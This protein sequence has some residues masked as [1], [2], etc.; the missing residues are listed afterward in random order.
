M[1]QPL[2]MESTLR[3]Q[4]IRKRAVAKG[5]LTRMQAYIDSGNFDVNQIQVRLNRLPTI[6]SKLE[7]VQDELEASDDCDHTEDRASFETQYFEIEAKF[8]ELLHPVNIHSSPD[9]S[10]EHGSSSSTRSTHTGSFQI[11]LPTIEIPC[12]DGNV[13]KWLHY[14]DT[15][16]ALIVNNKSLSNVQKFHYLTRVVPEVP[17]LTKKKKHFGKKC[18]YFST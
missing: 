14:K 12:F 17:D 16:E 1:E 18:L 8:H 13:C 4:L 7:A 15:F 2:K 9:N 11:R 3:E 6:L 10:S 5:M